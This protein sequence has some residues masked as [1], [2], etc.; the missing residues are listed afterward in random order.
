MEQ[1]GLGWIPSLAQRVKDLGLTLLCSRSR[2]WL[3]SDPCPEHRMPRGGQK[4]KKNESSR[5]EEGSTEAPSGL[6]R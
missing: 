1:R 2:L 3:G 6:S 4:R 5:S